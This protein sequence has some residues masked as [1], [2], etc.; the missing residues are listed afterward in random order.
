MITLLNVI[1]I[2]YPS[3]KLLTVAWRNKGFE[4]RRMNRG[5]EIRRMNRGFEIRIRNRG[6]GIR[7]RNRGLKSGG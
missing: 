5:F 6:F 3:V 7:R 4:I 2:Q 1:P